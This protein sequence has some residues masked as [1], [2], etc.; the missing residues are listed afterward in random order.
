MFNGSQI[1]MIAKK[2]ED[3]DTIKRMGESLEVSGKNKKISYY[4]DAGRWMYTESSDR[5]DDVREDDVRIVNINL[6]WFII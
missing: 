5:E 6:F 3:G 2:L 4:R 1:G